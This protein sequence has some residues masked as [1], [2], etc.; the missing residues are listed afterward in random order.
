MKDYTKIIKK[1][2]KEQKFS[3]AGDIDSGFLP[4]KEDQILA[5]MGDLFEMLQDVEVL[6]LK[7]K[8][9]WTDTRIRID[10]LHDELEQMNQR[11]VEFEETFTLLLNAMHDEIEKL[12]K[13]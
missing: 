11:L 4:D 13:D 6:S 12:Q 9:R 3:K 5:A 1:I 7:N 8:K 2:V 10:S